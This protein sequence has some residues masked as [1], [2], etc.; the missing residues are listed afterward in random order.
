MPLGDGRQTVTTAGTPVPL[1]TK[2]ST[3]CTS[4]TITA[5]AANTTVIAVG[6]PDV[7]AA[8]AGR[9]GT[10]LKAGESCKFTACHDHV[11]DLATVFIDAETSGEGVSYSYGHL[12]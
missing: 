9:K 11:D 3:A 8:V 6:G 1:I 4:V 12:A 5:L 7:A 2:A 10:I